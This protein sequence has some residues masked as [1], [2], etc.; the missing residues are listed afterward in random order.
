MSFALCWIFVFCSL[1]PFLSSVMRSDSTRRTSA[2][3][4]QNLV[5]R[6]LYPPLGRGGYPCYLEGALGPPRELVA[7][8]PGA[9]WKSCRHLSGLIR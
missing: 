5:F 1:K 3:D 2:R 7:F 9:F 6:E 4:Q 8:L